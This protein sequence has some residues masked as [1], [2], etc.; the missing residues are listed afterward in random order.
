MSELGIVEDWERD[1]FIVELTIWVNEQIREL[2][3][4]SK[5]IQELAN[6]LNIAEKHCSEREYK[7]SSIIELS[8]L[9]VFTDSICWRTRPDMEAYSW[10]DESQ[11]IYDGS[12]KVE[13]LPPSCHHRATIVPV[14]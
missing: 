9:K 4:K 12:W 7:L 10:D 5:T 11:L 3:E 8:D 13:P 1:D 14:S 6:I 2:A